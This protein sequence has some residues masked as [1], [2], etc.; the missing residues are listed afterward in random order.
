M[1]IAIT[2]LL[3]RETYGN[4]E[5]A[6]T[7]HTLALFGAGVLVLGLDSYLFGSIYATK[8][9]EPITD[10]DA[11]RHI[12][13]AAWLQIMPAAGMLGLGGILLVSGIGWMFAQHAGS[14][15]K[16]NKKFAYMAN[17]LVG[18]TIFGVTSLLILTSLALIDAMDR[19]F[20]E[21]VPVEAK[22]FVAVSGLA[23]ALA[24]VYMIIRRTRRFRDIP[25]DDWKRAFVPTYKSYT[26]IEWAAVAAAAFAIAGPI[27]GWILG[28]WQTFPFSDVHIFCSSLWHFTISGHRKLWES[29][30]LCLWFPGLVSLLIASSVPGSWRNL[31]TTNATHASNA[32]AG[33]GATAADEGTGTASPTADDDAPDAESDAAEAEENVTRPE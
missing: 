12:C 21:D 31:S 26:Y 32:V 6:P 20:N 22:S 24:A 23:I 2:F 18:L 9:P 15:T 19:V 4:K 16:P 33:G 29:I 1:V 30:G 8:P 14:S 7:T 17:T 28:H 11:A 25:P 27:W 3:G 10:A 13:E 5:A